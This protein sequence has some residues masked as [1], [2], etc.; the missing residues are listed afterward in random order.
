MKN[1]PFSTSIS[2]FLNIVIGFD[3]PLNSLFTK[4]LSVIT[5]FLS[6]FVNNSVNLLYSLTVNK[7]F[8]MIGFK[9]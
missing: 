9:S 1:E 4:A 3:I 7:S 2:I 6:T 5:K 8:N